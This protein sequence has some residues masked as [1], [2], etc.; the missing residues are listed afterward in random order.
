VQ[1]YLLAHRAFAV[2]A[3]LAL[4]IVVGLATGIVRT[5]LRDW[6][7]RLD[8]TGI[9]LRRRRGLLTRSDVT[10][11]FKRAQAALVT[12]GPVRVAFGWSELHIKNLAGDQGGGGAH[13]LAPLA[14]GEEIDHVLSALG[15]RPLPPEPEWRNVSTAYVWVFAFALSPLLLAAAIQTAIFWP[16]GVASAIAIAGAIGLRW[17][18]WLRTA[19]ALDADRVLIRSGWWRSRLLVLPFARIQ[20]ADISRNFISRWFGTS[21]LRL[22]VAGGAIAGEIIPAIP[23]AAARQL[24]GDL[25][26]SLA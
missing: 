26:V 19:Y 13:V 11:P 14:R 8:R 4:L 1:Q 18:S 7:F 20:S 10:L 5:L 12:T 3:G 17:L 21:T 23:S 22:G 16:L 2:S 24:R 9:G 15:W 6:G 25:L